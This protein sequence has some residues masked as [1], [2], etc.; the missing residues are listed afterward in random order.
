MSMNPHVVVTQA[1]KTK[2]NQV[3]PRWDWLQALQKEVCV[4]VW[5]ERLWLEHYPCHKLLQLL[6][7]KLHYLSSTQH[8]FVHE[9]S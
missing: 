3:L 2:I 6:Q 7:E 8:S 4:L 5:T 9:E 1:P